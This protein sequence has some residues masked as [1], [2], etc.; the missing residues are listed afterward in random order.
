M[1]VGG[2]GKTRENVCERKSV[3]ECELENARECV[4]VNE[5]MIK[6]EREIIR[7]ILE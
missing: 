4:Y 2:R 5:I 1:R 3:K 7:M 6:S